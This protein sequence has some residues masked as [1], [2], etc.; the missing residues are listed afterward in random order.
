MSFQIWWLIFL[1]VIFGFGWL[2]ARVDMRHVVRASSRLPRGYLRGLRHLLKDEEDR[3]ID[4]FVEV[5]DAEPETAELHFA[6]GALFRRRGDI[7]R[8]IRI[9]RAL[10]ARDDL[11]RAARE[12]ALLEL[13]RDYFKAGFWDRAEKLFEACRETRFAREAHAHLFLIF[14]REKSYQRAIEIAGEMDEALSQ[15]RRGDIAQ[16]YCEWAGENPEQ[17]RELLEK[18]ALTNPYCARA[19]ILLGELAAA[20][21]DAREAQARW[22]EVERRRPECLFLLAAPLMRAD[23]GENAEA[24]LR[25]WLSRHPSPALYE[26]VFDAVAKARGARA[27]ADIAESYLAAFDEAGALAKWAQTRAALADGDSRR[28]EYER[29]GVLAKRLR[30]PLRCAEC[31]FESAEFQWQCPACARWESFIPP[32]PRAPAPPLSAA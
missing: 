19:H 20:A 21:G 23:G 24:R 31:G 28:G 12:E 32:S 5:L 9:H 3:A 8:A 29:L 22:A 17:A 6:L 11:P 26:A 13:A 15:S 1:P 2:A 10:T 18:A 30:P 25:G 27:A 16:L 14:Q 7:E 4:A